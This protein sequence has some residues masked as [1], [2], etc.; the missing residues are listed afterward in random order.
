MAPD[1]NLVWAILTTIL[2]CW[3]F[4]IPAIVNAAK[5]D[6]YWIAGYREEAYEAA[7]KAKK[8]SIVSACV[9]VCFWVLYLILVVVLGVVSAGF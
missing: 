7:N 1:S 4:G 5:V 2:C 9:A 8:W 6:R 3:P